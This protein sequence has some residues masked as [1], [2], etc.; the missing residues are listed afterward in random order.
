M[1][2]M[3]MLKE[4]QR[5]VTIV[6][7]GRLSGGG[8]FGSEPGRHPRL[9]SPVP[10]PVPTANTPVQGMYPTSKRNQDGNQYA[11]ER[12]RHNRVLNG[13]PWPTVLGNV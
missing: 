11:A 3:E 10:T 1:S 9:P 2:E 7:D 6:L 12:P 4:P 5:I 13:K 8:T